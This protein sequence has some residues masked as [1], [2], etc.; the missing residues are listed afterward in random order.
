MVEEDK[1]RKETEQKTKQTKKR[2]PKKA[3]G[4]ETQPQVN[5]GAA[6]VQQQQGN[7]NMQANMQNIQVYKLQ[8]SQRF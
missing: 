8:I 4:A 7:P 6:K 5:A 1:R 2:Q 3:Q